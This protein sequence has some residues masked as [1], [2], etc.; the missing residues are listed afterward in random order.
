MKRWIIK[1]KLKK[2]IFTLKSFD[3]KRWVT[4]LKKNIFTLK[5]IEYNEFSHKFLTHSKK[6]KLF[7]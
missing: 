6:M 5:N 7:S 3:M 1:L 2:N 4:K